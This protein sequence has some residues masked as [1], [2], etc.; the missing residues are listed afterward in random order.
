MGP[1]DSDAGYVAHVGPSP[2]LYPNGTG[3]VMSVLHQ[4]WPAGHSQLISSWEPEGR[5]QTLLAALSSVLRLRRGTVVHVHITAGGSLVRKGLLLSVARARRLPTVATIH[6]SGFGR[7]AA[8]R[9]RITSLVLKQCG[10]VLALS[11]RIEAIVNDI[12]PTVRC[13]TFDNPVECPPE[14]QPLPD[15]PPRV[16][17]VGEIGTRKGVDVLVEAWPEIRASVPDAELE[18]VGPPTSLTVEEQPGLAVIGSQDRA[19][20]RARMAAAHLIVLPSRAET[21]PMVLLE[22]MSV[23]RA[24]IATDV[25]DVPSL[26][27]GGAG[28]LVPIGNAEELAASTVRL[29]ADRPALAAMGAAGHELCRERFD[30]D[31]VVGRL[32]AVYA[33]EAA[34]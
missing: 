28:V 4:A 19:Q 22:A 32:Q 5:V 33:R 1:A 25:G 17:F 3:S 26:E 29:L 31:A 34:R 18:I 20:V 2:V 7:F 6:G 12:A 16:L 15:G 10:T 14:P 21:L 8:K 30:V 11:P 9:P 23:G 27:A 13:Q 24:F